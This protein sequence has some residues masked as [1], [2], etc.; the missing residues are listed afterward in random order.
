M[1]RRPV[2]PA[3]LRIEFAR[4]LPF[5]AEIMICQ[6][7][8]I[9]REEN[10]KKSVSTAARS[11]SELIDKRIAELGDWRGEAL[12]RMRKRHVAQGALQ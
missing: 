11:A 9:A 5:N 10:M 1:I 7:R 4:R 3:Q 12:S 6:G 2:R 8:G